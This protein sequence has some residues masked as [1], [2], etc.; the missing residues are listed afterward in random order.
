MTKRERRDH[1]DTYM[2]RRAFTV[3]DDDED[4]ED[5]QAGPSGRSDNYRSSSTRRTG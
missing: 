1:L 5:T 2:I 3:L 4:F